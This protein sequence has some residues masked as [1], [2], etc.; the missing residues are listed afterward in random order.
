VN[1]AQAGPRLRLEITDDGRGFDPL[2][3]G[4]GRLGL[5]GMRE[6]ARLIGAGIQISSRPGSTTVAV[7]LSPRP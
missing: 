4:G 1:L 6:R 3:T 7:D 5:A 2:R